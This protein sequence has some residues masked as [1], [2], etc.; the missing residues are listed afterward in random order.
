TT[1]T[2]GT[3]GEFCKM[4]PFSPRTDVVASRVRLSSAG[5]DVTVGTDVS[6]N[7]HESGSTSTT[8]LTNFAEVTACTANFCFKLDTISAPGIPEVER[9]RMEEKLE[10]YQFKL[11]IAERKGREG[12]VAK[13]HK[14]IDRMRRQLAGETLGSGDEGEETGMSESESDSDAELQLRQRTGAGW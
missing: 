1:A 11:R 13:M 4:R 2:A 8:T 5:S 6:R 10:H 14:K 7:L 3:D 9:Q 12:K